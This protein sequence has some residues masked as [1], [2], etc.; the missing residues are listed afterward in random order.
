MPIAV[1][2]AKDNHHTVSHGIQQA[3]G[4]VAILNVPSALSSYG[5]AFASHN[6]VPAAGHA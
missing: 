3:L 1:V 4:Y 6:K 2:E 5:G